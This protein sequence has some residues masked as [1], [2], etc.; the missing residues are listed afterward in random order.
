MGSDPTTSVVNSDGRAHDVP[1]LYIA[2]G[3]VFV[4]GGAVNPTA[5]IVALAHRL[6]QHLV[7]VARGAAAA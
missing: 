3:S 7:S 5:T 2:D 1:N 6:A 4:T